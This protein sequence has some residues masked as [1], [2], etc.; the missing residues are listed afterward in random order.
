[1]RFQRASNMGIVVQ[2]RTTSARFPN[3]INTQLYAGMTVLDIVLLRLQSLCDFDVIP[4]VYV[5][6]PESGTSLKV[7]QTAEKWGAEYFVCPEHFAAQNDV[8]GRFKHLFATYGLDAC[9]RVTA[10]CPLIC[11]SLVRDCVTLWNTGQWDYVATD[12]I[13]GVDVEV[14]DVDGWLQSP[15][16]TRDDHEHVTPRY[17]RTCTALGRGLVLDLNRGMENW[18]KMSIDTPEDLECVR[19]F[20]RDKGVAFS[21]DDLVSYFNE[22]T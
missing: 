13:S 17:A 2:A 15:P 8:Y 9:V 12:G 10:D 20:L 3:K 16:L 1:M 22:V 18:P 14:F 5:A 11:T 7:R 19:A 21:Y 6:A 4:K